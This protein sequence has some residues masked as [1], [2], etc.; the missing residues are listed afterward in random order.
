MSKDIS[1]ND[2]KI[3][4]ELKPG[5]IG[6]VIYRHGYLYSV[7]YNY[8]IEFESYVAK[9]LSE[10][11]QN[12]EREQDRV[13]I[14]EHKKKI[15][16]FLLLMHRANDAAQLRYFLIEPEYRGIGLGSK[17][18]NFYM[19]FFKQCGY[20]KSY[21]WTTSEL[22]AAAKLYI[23]AGFKLVEEKKSSSFGKSVVEQKYEF[24]VIAS[25]L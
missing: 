19:D 25:E 23:K 8:G 15:I 13:W 17:L 11:Y 5:D 4:T 2:I 7:E 14:C 16:G 20:K 21:L 24:S 22:T 1:L 9:G 3:H 10:F 6:Y 18:M 12:Y